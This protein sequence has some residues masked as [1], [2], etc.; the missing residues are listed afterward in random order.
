MFCLWY[1]MR[2]FQRISPDMGSAGLV[3]NWV[4]RLGGAMVA[5]VLITVAASRFATRDGGP[6]FTY[7]APKLPEHQIAVHEY[8]FFLVLLFGA[9]IALII[10]SLYG[11]FSTGLRIGWQERVTQH[12]VGY[13]QDPV[14]CLRVVLC[15]LCVQLC[16]LRWK[17]RPTTIVGPLKSLD[18]PRFAWNWIALAVLTLVGMPTLSIYCFTFWLGPWYLYFP[19]LIDA[20]H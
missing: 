5:A 14:S 18:L 19:E 4:D 3:G 2:E 16:W 17:R 7:A 1:H 13:L 8:L 20:V 10:E 15:L 11:T 6:S 12:L 9:P